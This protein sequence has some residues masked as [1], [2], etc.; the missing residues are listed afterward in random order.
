M[1]HVQPSHP[2]ICANAAL[3]TPEDTRPS[4]DISLPVGFASGS[5]R[6]TRG[7][8]VEPA[9]RMRDQP[10]ATASRANPAGPTQDRAG[11]PFSRPRAWKR[12]PLRRRRDSR[13]R[14]H[15]EPRQADSCGRRECTIPGCHNHSVPMTLPRHAIVHDGPREGMPRNADPGGPGGRY[16]RPGLGYSSHTG[17]PLW[18]TLRQYRFASLSADNRRPGPSG[19][20]VVSLGL[21]R[22]PWNPV[23]FEAVDAYRQGT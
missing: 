1:K 18:T 22:S 13:T 9:H 5:G 17:A 23:E 12:R 7:P 20:D 8:T 14:P 11:P 19:R 4:G 15:C 6:S 3:A 21:G 16:I 2:D 10:R